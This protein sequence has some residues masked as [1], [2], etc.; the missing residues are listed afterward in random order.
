MED[1]LRLMDEKY[2]EL[3]SKYDMSREQFNR[4]YKKM[5]KDNDDLRIFIRMNGGMRA[6]V[7]SPPQSPIGNMHIT[8]PSPN[9]Q[10]VAVGSAMNHAMSK[11]TSAGSATFPPPAAE[12]TIKSKVPESAVSTAMSASFLA[13]LMSP[14]GNVPSVIDAANTVQTLHKSGAFDADGEGGET[15]YRPISAQSPIT[16]SLG[17]VYDSNERRPQT[18][19]LNSKKNKKALIHVMD[20]ITR[21]SG[22]KSV[23]SAER[24]SS[25]LDD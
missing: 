17:I 21:H 24:L 22:K 6:T 20:K 7:S 14:K 18:S 1:Q 5:S 11:K 23:W 2:L 12:S 9:S 25:L 15:L 8:I 10:Y 13:G 19:S 4:K 3:K 16:R